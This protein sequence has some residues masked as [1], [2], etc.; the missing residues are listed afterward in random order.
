MR[1]QQRASGAACACGHE[2][3][4]CRP[5]SAPLPSHLAAPIPTTTRA[6]P[7]VVLADRDQ[8]VTLQRLQYYTAALTRQDSRR[9]VGAPRGRQADFVHMFT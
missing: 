6:K 3:A 8:D 4:Q 9:K 7:Q 5:H 2:T 1:A